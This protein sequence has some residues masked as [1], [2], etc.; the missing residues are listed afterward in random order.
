M[1][2]T[3]VISSAKTG[4]LLTSHQLQ[5][6]YTRPWTLEVVNSAMYHSLNDNQGV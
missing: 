2:S 6:M 1:S 4:P 3:F 5:G